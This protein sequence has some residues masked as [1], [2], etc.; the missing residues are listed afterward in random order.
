M[1][2]TL[3]RSTKNPMTKQTSETNEIAN[4]EFAAKANRISQAACPFASLLRSSRRERH[5]SPSAI[6]QMSRQEKKKK[7]KR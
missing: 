4:I 5:I 6:S 1:N 2:P 3:N 7:K